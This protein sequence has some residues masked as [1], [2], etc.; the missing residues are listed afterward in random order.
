MS[1]RTMTILALTATGCSIGMGP[2]TAATRP[3]LGHT[4]KNDDAKMWVPSADQSG[5]PFG[6]VRMEWGEDSFAKVFNYVSITSAVKKG[7]ATVAGVEDDSKDVIEL[8]L[9]LTGRIPLPIGGISLGVGRVWSLEDKANVSGLGVR[10]SIAPIAQFSI[11]F[12]RS[13]VGGSLEDDSGMM[14]DLS[15]TRTSLG[16]TVLLWGYNQFRFGVAVAKAW[17]STDHYSSDGY[18]Y[19]LVSTMY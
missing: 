17:T 16:G 3:V 7:S 11:D 2:S 8:D 14:T 13:W 12:A 9:A 18:T 15:G 5:V 6:F 19:T 1:L 10:A 4:M